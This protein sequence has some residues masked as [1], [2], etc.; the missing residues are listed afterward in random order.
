[1]A[2][3]LHVTDPR[4][5]GMYEGEMPIAGPETPEARRESNVLPVPQ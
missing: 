2:D 5:V 3:E 4:W 1:M